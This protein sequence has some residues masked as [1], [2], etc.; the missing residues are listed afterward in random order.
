VLSYKNHMDI[1]KHPKIFNESNFII[2]LRL[3]F[4]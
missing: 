3:R 1:S 2:Y 4:C